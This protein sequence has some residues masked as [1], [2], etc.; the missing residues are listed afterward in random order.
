M[1][2]SISW[3]KEFTNI[4]YEH[5][6][7]SDSLSMAGFEVESIDDLSR[8][9]EGIVIG[10]IED[11]EIHPNA[12][13]LSICKVRVSKE[14][15]LQIVC[16]ANNVKEHV[17]VPVALPGAY[18]ATIDLKIKPTK[19]R[20]IESIGMICSK[21][22]LG[23]EKSSQGIFILEEEFDSI[24]TIGSHIGK[25]LGLD[26]YILDIAI[27]ANRPDGMSIIGIARELAAINRLELVLPKSLNLQFE[28]ENILNKFSEYIENDSI[29]SLMKID[30]VN[31]KNKSSN[32]IQKRLTNLGLKPRN[33]II[34]I[35]NY[36]MLEQGQPF[37]AFD[38][39]RLEKLT[40]KTIEPND[41]E[42]RFAKE[43]E[44]FE[45]ID[46]KLIFLKPQTLLVTCSNT[47]VAIAGIIGSS[48]SCV[49]E[50]TKRVYIESAVFR[51]KYIRNSS[52]S[53]STRTDASTRFEKGIPG[54]ITRSSLERLSYLFKQEFK[55]CVFCTK[56]QGLLDYK[57]INIPLRLKKIRK[58]LGLLH[59]NETVNRLLSSDP[60]KTSNLDKSL[61]TC[62]IPEV[63]V[64]DILEHLGCNLLK[65]SE[66]WLVKIPSYRNLDLLREIDLIEEIARIIGF[67]NFV[68]NL[69]N[70]LSPGML[71]PL[72]QI[73]RKINLLMCSSGFQEVNTISLVSP[74]E[75]NFE[76][77]KISNPLFLETSH[78]RTDLI[79]EH[80]NICQ[81]NL[82]NGKE[83]I[84]IYEIGNVHKK[85]LSDN[86]LIDTELLMGGVI[87]GR[88]SIENWSFKKNQKLFSYYEARGLL[89]KLFNHLK[90]EIEDIPLIDDNS[91]HPGR[92]SNLKLEGKVLG[93]F[94][95]I[96]PI[97]REKYS[98]PVD[99]YSFT[100]DIT[101][102][103]ISASR[104][105]KLNISFKEF[106]TYPPI[107]RDVSLL[108]NKE[109]YSG[110]I[111]NLIK[112]NGKPILETVDLIDKF[113]NLGK[114]NIV[115]LTYRLRYRKIKST[116]T[117]QDIQ[118]VHQK[119]ISALE[120]KLKA[121]IRK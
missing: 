120:G 104:S 65:N 68:I 4:P 28:K 111:I 47:P 115:S 112:K 91:L 25:L 2:L 42:L 33:A 35:L 76:S 78:L 39:D 84:W 37:H 12:E 66:G 89:E 97:I 102:I 69:P 71:S 92:S 96:H 16:G 106:S 36:V 38:I 75:Q 63:L 27:T 26:D 30:N 98:L 31:G 90:I 1:R 9:V 11:I 119:I 8:N 77:V 70:P 52:Q 20:G 60:K 40:G 80:L 67:D 7:L 24:P 107:D 10:F 114:P 49:T 22:E 82:N 53:I 54:G 17:H 74:K 61:Q 18:L 86:T 6:D 56:Y 59:P 99:A 43:Q 13:K 58:T 5:E 81:R 55:D 118:S 44:Q 100:I 117:E 34:D 83:S 29:Y 46:G 3:L 73:E 121:E 23:L 19:L 15:V 110:Q 45:T 41:F 88:R 101:K 94:G 62:Q 64:Q 50:D 103:K 95:E 113:D 93:K 57:S 109:V 32:L 79:E 116:L 48:N 105:N 14:Q 87:C 72:Q 21:S 51:S 85:S 108:I